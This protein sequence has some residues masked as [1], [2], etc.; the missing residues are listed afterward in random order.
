[1]LKF[2]RYLLYTS[3]LICSFCFISL[4]VH[5]INYVDYSKFKNSS[6]VIFF[7]CISNNNCMSDPSGSSFFTSTS[8]LGN[9]ISG[10]TSPSLT[11]IANS[12][13]ISLRM[14]VEEGFIKDNY[15]TVNFL[16]EPPSSNVHATPHTTN[17]KQ[18]GSGD[19]YTSYNSASQASSVDFHVGIGVDFWGQKIGN[20][21]LLSYTFKAQNTGN[22]VFITFTSLANATGYWNLYG[23]SYTSHGAS[24]PSADDI[25]NSLQS[26]FNSLES[27]INNNINNM[28][29]S[30]N[31]NIDDMKEKQ[32]ETNNKLDDLNN[33]IT[34]DSDDVSSKSCGMLCKLKGIWNGIINLPSNIW[35][36]LKGGFEAITDG[37]SSLFEG[38]LSIFTPEGDKECT[39]SPNLFNPNDLIVYNLSTYTD[40]NDFVILDS[41]VRINNIGSV[42][43]NTYYIYLGTFNYNEYKDKTFYLSYNLAKSDISSLS[44]Y[45]GSG[46]TA[47]N[48]TGFSIKSDGSFSLL[49]ISNYGASGSDV[50]LWIYVQFNAPFGRNIDIT[51]IMFTVDGP[52]EYIPYGSEVCTTVESQSFLGWLGSFFSNI[53][54]GIIELPSKL[55]GLL[56]EALKNLFVP[57]EEQLQ[58]IITDSQELAENFGFVGETIS[59]F[60][61]IFTS[62]LGLSNGNGCINFPEFTIGGTSLFK[63][64]TFW[65]AQNVCLAD[66]PILSANITTIRTITSIVLV[67]LFVNFASRE[68]WHVLNKTDSEEASA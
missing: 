8:S 4:D 64:I 31:N 68:F 40:F 32:D 14:Y 58:E 57:T 67:V 25:K 42:P 9:T 2:I 49:D 24:T 60:I 59:F 47:R 28:E 61:G 50:S 27:S 1:M 22:Y 34:S 36:S 55:V 11:T 52:S 15:Y 37:I 7:N 6:D 63:S 51:D 39:P 21:S 56:I 54:T 41:G 18:V 13:G 46:T 35:N 44:I 45:E 66:N 3:I 33:S 5:A 10:Y 12:S 29:N 65:K 23:Y 62:L 17:T 19:T 48:G 53:I 30:I 38:I 26:S 43:R 20:F 16:L